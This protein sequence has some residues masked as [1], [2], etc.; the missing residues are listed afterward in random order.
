MFFYLNEG[1]FIVFFM[2]IIILCDSFILGLKLRLFLGDDLNI[3]LKFVWVI[4]I[5][6]VK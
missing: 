1:D 4:K 5:R 3:K 6:F 2:I